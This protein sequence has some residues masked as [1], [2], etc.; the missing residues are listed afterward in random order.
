MEILVNYV[1]CL[2]FDD[3]MA[4]ELDLFPPLKNVNNTHFSCRK[5]KLTVKN[6]TQQ[7]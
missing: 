2:G 7:Y 6:Y 3:F 4:R 1:I 5:T